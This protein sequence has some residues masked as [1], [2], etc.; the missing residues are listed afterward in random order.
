[1]IIKTIKCVFTAI[2]LENYVINPFEFQVSKN[3]HPGFAVEV[4]TGSFALQIKLAAGK[5]QNL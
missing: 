5:S 1:M 4:W 2:F 3:G